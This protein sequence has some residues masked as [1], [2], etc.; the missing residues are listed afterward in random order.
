MTDNASF[1][2]GIEDSKASR[3]RDY[4]RAGRYLTVID[5]FKVKQNDE[6]V[7]FYIFE[8]T[9][10][11]VLDDSEALKTPDPAHSIGH[12]VSWA[13]SRLKKPTLG[14]LKQALMVATGV[15]EASITGEF[16]AQLSSD[17]N[18]L[19]GIPV[20]FSNAQIKTKS[21]APFTQIRAKR[22]WSKKEVEAKVGVEM[23]SQLKV[24]IEDMG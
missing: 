19:R 7:V 4:F 9:I 16:C 1:F 2:K 3:D 20:E 15:P 12:R 18:P 24:E 10:L 13:M 8:L 21:G 22:R 11:A 23:L 17:L 14:N 6:G 5:A